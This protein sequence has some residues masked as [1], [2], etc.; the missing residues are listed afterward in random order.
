MTKTSNK[1][2]RVTVRL[3]NSRHSELTTY[4][5][6]HEISLSKAIET[7]VDAGL[8]AEQLHVATKEDVQLLASDIKQHNSELEKSLMIIHNAIKNQPLVTHQLTAPAD[9]DA[10]CEHSRLKRAWSVLTGKD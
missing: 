10:Q 3:T 6:A 5:K 7:L 1:E 2:K 9:E 8:K 4:A